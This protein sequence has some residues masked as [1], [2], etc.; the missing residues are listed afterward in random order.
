MSYVPLAHV[1]TG[2][3]ATAALHN[4]HLDN[5]D[6]V[7]AG[8]LAISS[9]AALDFLYA[10]SATQMARLARGTSRQYPRIKS[11]LSAWE[12][13]STGMELLYSNSGTTTNTGAN[14]MDSY[15]LASGLGAKDTL[16][17]MM[18]WGTTTQPSGQQFLRNTTDTVNLIAAA[19]AAL[20]AGNY[21]NYMAILR[22]RQT[23]NTKVAV[24]NYS[25]NGAEA[26]AA[27]LQATFTTPWTGAWTIGWNN[28]GVT[29]GGTADWSWAIYALRG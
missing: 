18:T 11:D 24:T 2:D 19:W 28:T 26:W 4:T 15:A 22:Q 9:Q 6:F 29:A 20:T 12:F 14:T 5:T 10:S 25:G 1:A 27:G 23:S 7:Y 3:T 16:L 21:Y 17:V 8:G 13:A